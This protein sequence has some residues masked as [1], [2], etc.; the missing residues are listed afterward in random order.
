MVVLFAEL[1]GFAFSAVVKTLHRRRSIEFLLQSSCLALAFV[2]GYFCDFMSPS[3]KID[4]S[5]LQKTK[6]S[7]SEGGKHTWE[8]NAKQLLCF[9]VL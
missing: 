4:L 1:F 2:L 3:L 7:D 6:G 8:D 9:S 5:K